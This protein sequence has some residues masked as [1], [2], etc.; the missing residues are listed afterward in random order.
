MEQRII[1]AGSGGQGILFLGKVLAHVAIKE[2]KEV[3]WFPSYGAEIRGGT[4]NCM[5]VISDELIGSPIVKNADY[6]IVLN[7]ASFNK[8]MSR[9]TQGGYLIYDSS[10]IKNSKS[11]NDINVYPVNASQ[12]ASLI[13][14]PRLANM[15]LLGAFVKISRIFNIEKVLETI[16]EIIPPKRKEMI[17]I[18]KS[19]ILRGFSIVES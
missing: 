2:N 15:V 10:I 9:V 4:A 17:E 19:L 18:N 7:E 14:N 11:L 12:E 1:I 5:V 16:E 6:L 13:A 8:F 3:T